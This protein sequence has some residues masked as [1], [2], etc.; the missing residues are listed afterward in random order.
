M[1][2][3]PACALKHGIYAVRVGLDGRVHDGVANFGRR[4]T[5]GDGAP[6]LEV[7]LFDFSGELYGRTLDVAFIG[8]IRAELRFDGIED[9][10]RHMDDDSR[11]ARAVLARAGDVFPP[12]GPLVEANSE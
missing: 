2:L 6:L 4:P 5:F 9:L 11:L 7:H 10:I 3:D 8:W 1:Q 12:I